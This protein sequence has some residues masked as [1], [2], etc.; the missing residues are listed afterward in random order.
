MEHQDLASQSRIADLES[1]YWVGEAFDIAVAFDTVVEEAFIGRKLFL[2][3]FVC[4]VAFIRMAAE[5]QA[6]SGSF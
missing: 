4:E 5:M 1:S 6:G 2:D 3:H